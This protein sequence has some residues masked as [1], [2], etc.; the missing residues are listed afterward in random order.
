MR[1]NLDLKKLGAWWS[2]LIF[3]SDRKG[4][5]TWV[6]LATTNTRRRSRKILGGEEDICQNI[7]SVRR[8]C[9]HSDFFISWIQRLFS[10]TR[11]KLF[12]I[13]IDLSDTNQQWGRQTR[14][15]HHTYEDHKSKL[16]TQPEKLLHVSKVTGCCFILS[17]QGLEDSKGYI[18][19]IISTII[20]YFCSYV[21]RW[22]SHW[23]AQTRA[24]TMS[25]NNSKT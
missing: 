1:I 5:A 19:G 7:Y 15:K 14:P 3:Q 4:N 17:F 8:I 11:L 12:G 21:A 16:K 23:F 22:L 9:H 20:R 25:V 18:N 13:E 2:R 10:S 24:L 6:I